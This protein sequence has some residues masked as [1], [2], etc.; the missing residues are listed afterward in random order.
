MARPTNLRPPT[1][2]DVARLAGVSQTTVSFVLNNR[3]DIRI[4]D[5]TK[6]RIREAVEELGYRPNAVAQMLRTSKTNL[7]GMISDEIATTPHAGKIIKGA[8]DTAWAN[9]K[10]LLMIN[11][12][13]NQEVKHAA[14]NALLE[15]Q[16][17]G[18]IYATMYHRPVHPPEIL[19]GVPT[20]LLDCF[21]ADKSLPSVV[22]DEVQ[23]G[24]TATEHLLS[25]G[26]RRIGFI[27]DIDP[28]P[29]TFGRL[30]GYREA[31]AAYGVAYDH[32]L[33]VSEVS[34]AGGG[35]R[36]AM[37]LM[38]RDDRPTALFCF[39]DRMA[40]GAYDALRKLGI[41]IAQDVAIVGFDNEEIIAAHLYPPLTT[42]QLPH[43]QMGEWAVRYLI[44]HGA[45]VPDGA[46]IQHRIECPLV[47]RT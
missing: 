40:M 45:R 13:G 21:V 1:M 41:G 11:T 26:H 2:T 34:N 5:E 36:G 47:K 30:E 16:V 19:H 35:Y 43:Y 42:V 15:R 18:V 9:G 8:Q 22:P 6:L 28:I 44:E 25:Y 37:E 24:S 33:V 31:L 4:A 32:T 46:P 7:I 29:A 14:A 20:V 12:D 17:E 10:L 23:G 27:N 3:D 39:N 38:D